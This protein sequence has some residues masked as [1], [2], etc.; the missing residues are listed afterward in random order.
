MTMATND[1]A[2]AGLWMLV[3][4][5]IVMSAYRL[6]RQLFSAKTISSDVLVT[7][8]LSVAA[9]HFS[10]LVVGAIGTFHRWP[11]F[12]AVVFVTGLLCFLERWSKAATNSGVR[13]DR[14]LDNT[15]A[16]Q[17]TSPAKSLVSLPVILWWIAIS[18]FTGHVINNGLLSFPVDW[19]TLMYHLP[20]ID[21]WIQSGSLA[22][23]QSARWST[24]ATGELIGTWFVLPFS[25]DF[26]ASLTNVPMFILMASSVIETAR[27]IGL[28]GSWP[29]WVAI[30]TLATHVT[31][32]QSVDVSNDVA[33][34]A[35][36]LSGLAFALRYHGDRRLADASLFGVCFGLLCGVKFFALG[37]AAVLLLIW[38]MI[39]FPVAVRLRID[40][41]KHHLLAG[42]LAILSGGYWYLRNWWM[43][44]YLLYPKGSPDM[45]QRILYD[46]LSRTTLLGNGDPSVPNLLIGAVWKMTGPIHLL[47]LAIL[48]TMAIATIV[49]SISLMVRRRW[50]HGRYWLDNDIYLRIVLTVGVIGCGCVWIVTPMLVE[51]Q[52]GTL[53]HLRWGYAPVRY[54]LTFLSMSVIGLSTLIYTVIRDMPG[55]IRRVVSLLFAGT[56]ICQMVSLPMHA[57]QFDLVT[58]ALIGANVG[59][60]TFILKMLAAKFQRSKAFLITMVVFLICVAIQFLSD[61]WHTGFARHFDRYDRT[62]AYSVMGDET[63]RMIVLSNRVYPLLGSRR[64]NSILQPMLYYGVDAV[65]ESCEAFNA[66]IV[67]TRV[68]DHKILARY[69]PS[70]D[71]LSKDPRF[72]LIDLG[73]GPLKLFRYRD[74][75]GLQE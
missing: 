11:A 28:N 55:R 13:S 24:P 31:L 8:A 51:D 42:T 26:L 35:F 4:I 49:V 62:T 69:R 63:H 71:E 75:S 61:R 9:I 20:F 30:A 47:A 52:P 59:L 48:P 50:K 19:D 27:R 54:G 14:I 3:S 10:L 43:T 45:S 37:Y 56:I 53:N 73:P 33:V 1:A 46:D 21:F 15:D 32:R 29:H 72:E 60:A 66:D 6:C 68:D 57:V 58:A 16:F 12:L 41:I 23:M 40:I 18:A 17:E 39:S 7:T 44:G 34:S 70:W 2:M 65:V 36:F 22:S 25:G 5:A 64:Q 67:V 38:V 74:G